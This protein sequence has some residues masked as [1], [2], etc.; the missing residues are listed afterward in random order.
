MGA[1]AREH[2][3][4]WKLVQSPQVDE[5]IS[6]PGNPGLQ[7]LGPTVPEIS[8]TDTAALSSYAVSEEIDLVIVGPEDPLAGGLVDELSEQGVAAFG[9]SRAAARL[10]SSKWFAKEIMHRAG[11]PTGAAEPFTDREPALAALAHQ[12]PPF[13]IKA[14]GL[15]A[16]KGVLVTDD[17]TKAERWIDYCLAGGF[18]DAG[19]TVLIE[20]YL[21]GPELSLFFLCDG[22]DA[23]PLA[24]A[25]DYKRLG[26]GDFGPNTGGM[27][28]YSPVDLPSGLEESALDEVVRPVLA[29]LHDDGTPYVGFLYLGLVLTPEGLRVLEFNVRL[30]DPEAQV[31]L[32]RL[33]DDLV[34]LL[35]GALEGGI[36]G[37]MPS[38][39]ELAAVN[40][41]LAASGYPDS[42]RA[43]DAIRGLPE[44]ET[45]PGALIFHAGTKRNG[46]LLETAGGRVLSIVGLA[47]D[48]LAA[49]NVAYRAASLISWDGVEFRRDIAGG[50]A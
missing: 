47:D 4:G 6:I 50:G 19:R 28:S 8:A 16:G 32:P 45:I 18:G 5:L 9:P 42:P 49:R 35:F 1:G 12:Q 43:G 36:T 23:I 30:G 46:T 14:D 10:E 24:P 29:V 48:L 11:V 3:L 13:V 38:W 27:G 17:W 26:D 39:S 34:P 21:A 25:R 31:I 40:V 41:V 22:K 2:S 15:A 37:M 7:Q 20:E 44:A 33:E